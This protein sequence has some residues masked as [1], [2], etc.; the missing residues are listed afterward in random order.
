MRGL[1]SNL[2]LAL[3]W[4]AVNG[5]FQPSTLLAGFLLGYVLLAFAGTT[6]EAA[7]YG[8][9]V[10]CAGELA[11]VFLVEL[12]RANLR[13]AYDVVTPQHRMRPAILRVPLDARSD[14]EITLLSNLITLTPGSLALEVSADRRVLYVHA[15]YAD[16]DFVPRIKRVLEARV[17]RLMR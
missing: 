1:L 13:V 16:D 9:K 14:G 6:R 3:V 17:L 10:R 12:L 5:D 8:R 11:V 15:M 7:R 4:C 2:W